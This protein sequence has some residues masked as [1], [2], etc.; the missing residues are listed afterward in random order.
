VAA[1]LDADGRMPSGASKAALEA[2]WWPCAQLKKSD[3]KPPNVNVQQDL[4]TTKR[5]PSTASS[6]GLEAA[7]NQCS[8][9]NPTQSSICASPLS[10]PRNHNPHALRTQSRRWHKETMHRLNTLLRSL[11]QLYCPPILATPTP[12]SRKQS[13]NS[14]AQF[15]PGKIQSYTSSWTF[16]EGHEV[17]I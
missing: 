13:S 15:R 1:T 8:A 12:I 7:H 9:Q 16:R 6:A 10:L 17:A 4:G 11:P 3:K 2:G 5:L 14:K